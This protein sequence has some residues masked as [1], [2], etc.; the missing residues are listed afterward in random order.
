MPP[1]CWW[2]C[3]ASRF[4]PYEPET[5]P[6]TVHLPEIKG[7]RLESLNPSSPAPRF[8]FKGKLH[9]GV[10]ELLALDARSLVQ[11]ITAD[12]DLGIDFTTDFFKAHKAVGEAP[13][14]LKLG[15]DGFKE[16]LPV[17]QRFS[18]TW[19]ALPLKKE[20]ALLI[21]LISEASQ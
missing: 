1:R 5:E 20:C 14:T 18:I 13:V 16:N 9:Q 15:F 3:R 19:T 11:K 4:K 21:F 10:M 17:L 2:M 12:K 7:L 8:G 6:Q